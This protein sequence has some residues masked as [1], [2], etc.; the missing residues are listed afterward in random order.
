[1]TASEPHTGRGGAL[2]RR[3]RRSTGRELSE[4]FRVAGAGV[5][6]V[7]EEAGARGWG[8]ADVEDAGWR[9]RNCICEQ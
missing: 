4:E 2:G 5:Q 7:G 3:E 8:C 1:M 6:R 9:I